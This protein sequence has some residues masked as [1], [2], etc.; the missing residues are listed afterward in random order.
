MRREAYSKA[1]MQMSSP[2]LLFFI[3]MNV[4]FFIEGGQSMYHQNFNSTDKPPAAL[5]LESESATAHAVSGMRCP[6]GWHTMTHY[7]A[8][9]LLISLNSALRVVLIPC[10]LKAVLFCF[11]VSD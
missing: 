2:F 8:K 9:S 10:A 7:A 3:Y 1:L 4:N 6:I 5:R 11:A